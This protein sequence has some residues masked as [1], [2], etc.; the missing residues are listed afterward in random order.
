MGEVGLAVVRDLRQPT[1]VL[2]ELAVVLFRDSEQVGDDQQRE[3]IAVALEHLDL[4]GLDELVDLAIGEPPCERFVLAHALRGEEAQC[5]PSL[6]LMGLTV[7]RDRVLAHREL[8]A[9]LRQELA[10]VVGRLGLDR[11]AREGTAHCVAR[12]ERLVIAQH[13]GGV[14]VGGHG[15]HVVFGQVHD[16]ALGTQ[17]GEVRERIVDD[18]LVGVEV[19]L[20]EV[21]HTWPPVPRYCAGAQ[22]AVQVLSTGSLEA[23]TLGGSMRRWTPR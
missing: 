12:R 7:Q 8:V 21:G 1:E 14:V 19:H 17:V 2:A 10:D 20:L 13:A 9:V 5:E 4:A 18:R 11:E 23:S 22:H 16:R 15:H 3:G 6:G